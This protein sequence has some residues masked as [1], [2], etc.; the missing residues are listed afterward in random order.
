MPLVS[1]NPATGRVVKTF[2]PHGE[3][4]IEERLGR[5]VSASRAWRQTKPAERAARLARAAEV[6]TAEREPWSRLMVE[7]MGK[8]LKAARGEIDKCAW[9]FRHYAEHGPRLIADETVDGPGAKSY[10]HYQPLGAVLAVMPW[11]FPFWQVI[12]FAAPSLMAGNVGVLKHASN[13]PRCAL[14]LEELFQRAGFPEGIFQTLLVGNDVVARLIGDPRIAAVTL[15]GSDAAGAAVAEVAGKHLKKS[16]LELGGSDP[17]IIMPSADLPKAIETAVAARIINNGQS[18]IAAKR[19]IAHQAVY[20]AVAAGMAERLG[21]LRVGDPMNEDTDVG[22]LATGRGRDGLADQVARLRPARA[23]T[24]RPGSSPTCRSRH[25]WPRRSSSA[26]WRCST[27]RAT[28]TTRS[29]SPTTRRSASARRRGPATPARSRASCA[30]S[31]TARP[32]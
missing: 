17:F 27:A 5:A 22:P 4:E 8:T 15:T 13:V 21:K 1:Q 28:S 10:I 31:R 3:R 29:S 20:D 16:V 7:E 12:R 14:A 30:T 6:L 25:R 32:S 23:P 18:C 9:T 11:N 26:R 24:S 19:F 2:E